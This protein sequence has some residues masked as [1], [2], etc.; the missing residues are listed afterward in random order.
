MDA[1][2]P[3]PHPFRA[4]YSPAALI[5][6]SKT[7]D[8]SPTR[9][10]VGEH[11]FA[12]RQGVRKDGMEQLARPQKLHDHFSRASIERKF[13]HHEGLMDIHDAVSPL[14]FVYNFALS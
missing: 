14:F 2:M 6:Y 11:Q 9:Q 8:P 12:M 13:A 4:A 5:A 3:G 10:Q 1:I 7:M